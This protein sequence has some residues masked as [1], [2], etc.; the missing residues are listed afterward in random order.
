M[1]L[2][3]EINIHTVINEQ[4][5]WKNNLGTLTLHGRKGGTINIGT[6]HMEIVA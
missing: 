4:L 5:A 3:I 2:Q 1:Q 6:E